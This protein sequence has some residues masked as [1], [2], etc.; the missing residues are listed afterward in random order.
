MSVRYQRHMPFSACWRCYFIRSKL[1]KS[2]W[3]VYEGA[4]LQF[5]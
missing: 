4:L 5:Q 3:L 1:S 2:A